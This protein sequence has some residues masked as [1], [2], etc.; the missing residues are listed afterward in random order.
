MKR[1]KIMRNYECR[2]N[3]NNRLGSICFDVPYSIN[4][5]TKFVKWIGREMNA[6]VYG[7]DIELYDNIIDTVKSAEDLKSGGIRFCNSAQCRAIQN[8]PGFVA[9]N[10]VD[11]VSFFVAD[12]VQHV[13]DIQCILRS[14]YDIKSKWPS[15]NDNF[16]PNDVFVIAGVQSNFVTG[17]QTGDK[18]SGYWLKRFNVTRLDPTKDILLNRKLLQI[19]PNNTGKMPEQL[20][21]LFKSY[22]QNVI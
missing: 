8:Q 15:E 20:V 6:D 10:K 17:L 7:L 19:W 13:S 1:Y 16:S 4:T 12:K 22:N 18:S 21:N 5:P 2:L 14:Q 3:L 9:Q 11:G